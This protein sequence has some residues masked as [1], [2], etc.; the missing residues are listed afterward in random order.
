[1]TTVSPT[2]DPVTADDPDHVFIHRCDPDAVAAE[3]AASTGPLAGLR[4]AVKDNTDVAG[5][6]TTAGCP[7]FAYTPDTS[8]TVIERLVDAGATVVGKTNLDQFATGLVGTRSPYGVVESPRAPGRVAG[9]SSSG[10]A[11]AV[12]LG[13]ADLAIGTDTAGSGRVPAAFCGVVGIK[14]TRGWV[15]NTGT[16]PACA[17]FDCT[18]IFAPSVGAAARA[19]LVMAGPDAADPT[20]RA[21]PLDGPHGPVRVVGVPGADVLAACDE[22]TRLGFAGATARAQACGFTVAEVDLGAY[23]AAGE[24]L[25]G[26]GFVAERHASVGAFIDAGAP[27]ADPTVA[28]I[29]GAAG[30][31]PATRYA[32]DR[33]RLATMTAEADRLWERVDAILTPTTPFHPTV[34]DVAADPSGVNLALGRFTSG[35]N[36][37]DWCAVALPGPD[38]DD[39][40]PFGVQLLGP[41][42]ADQVLWQAAATLLDEEPPAGPDGLVRLAVAGA[43]LDGQPLNHQLTDRRAVLEARTTTAP[44]YRMVAIDG[45]VAKPGVYRVDP[46]EGEALEVE[47]W[48]LD[49]AGFGTFVAEV[50]PPLAIGTVELADGSEVPGFVC[51]PRAIDGATDITR[52]GGW[53]GWLASRS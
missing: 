5:V 34:A 38:L 42:W 11:A 51:E 47:V 15:P 39:G 43:H 7:S 21:R 30:R 49:P 37:V 32:A 45:P 35:C 25:Y 13:Q 19:I 29:I 10:S 12:A 53:R 40:L 28:S 1:M 16:V 52:F 48:A 31:I 9:G 22:R 50:P 33:L 17:S 2:P 6:P 46:A 14:A 3:L 27:D 20:S 26:G 23:L 18:T 44:A 24:L 36:L 4:L 41:A 8:A